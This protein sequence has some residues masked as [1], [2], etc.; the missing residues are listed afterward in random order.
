MT[1]IAYALLLVTMMGTPASD[2]VQERPVRTL[3]ADLRRSIQQPRLLV[4][5]ALS[6]GD[7]GLVLLLVFAAA[8]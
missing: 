5:R 7:V 6:H 8:T 4:Y 3:N 2:A 1:R